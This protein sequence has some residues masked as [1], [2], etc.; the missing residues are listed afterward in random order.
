MQVEQL[1][2]KYLAS[3]GVTTDTRNIGQGNIFFALKGEKF[4]ANEFAAEAL[5]KGAACVVIDELINPH[6]QTE[7]GDRLILVDD[8]LTTLQQ[9]SGYHRQQLNCPVIAITGS[10]GKTTTKELVAA[11]LAKKYRTY[12]TKGNLNNHIGI[13]LTLLSIKDDVE[14]AVIEMGANHQGEIAGYCEYVKP[15]YGLITNVGKA[16]LEGFGGFEGVVKGKTELYRDIAAR[17][18]KVFINRNNEILALIWAGLASR[19]SFEKGSTITYGSSSDVF[20]SGIIKA[21]TEF[22]TISTEGLD[23][24]TNLLGD[25]N[26]E[27]VM[28]AI[29]IGK[30]FEVPLPAIKNAIETYTPTNNR[31]QKIEWGS[32]TI[33]LDAYNANPSSMIE[34]LK[35]FEKYIAGDNTKKGIA[36]IGQMMELG[37]YAAQEH[38]KIFAAAN[39]SAWQNIKRVFVG[40]G[41]EMVKH[42]SA[43]NLLWFETTDEV[44]HWFKQQAFENTLLLIKGSRKNELEKILKN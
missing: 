33:I 8:V 43:S 5:N 4:N 26:F 39:T 13:P 40:K 19:A 2:Q 37:E 41:F 9:L 25:Y 29:C 42:L 10:N 32:N 14:M 36:I 18:G 23:I 30:Y 38:E 11:V 15:D 12:A 7:Y 35:N 34:A 17:K 44:K 3:T 28:S 24:S 27:N 6:W 21:G 31:S 16:H 1:Y 20:S 22:L